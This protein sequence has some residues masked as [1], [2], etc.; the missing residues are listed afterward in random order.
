MAAK[1]RELRKAQGCKPMR[2]IIAVIII[3]AA[4]AAGLYCGGMIAERRM[5]QF[6]EEVK[7]ETNDTYTHD[8]SADDDAG[9]CGS[10]KRQCHRV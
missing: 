10:F 5:K 9:P 6:Y 4:F 7:H 3:L 8:S 1:H 2:D